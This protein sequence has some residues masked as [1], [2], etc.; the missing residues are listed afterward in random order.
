ME[1]TDF[2]AIDE[3]MAAKKKKKGVDLGSSLR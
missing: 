1:D 2:L 3:R